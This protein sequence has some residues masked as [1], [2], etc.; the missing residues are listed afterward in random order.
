MAYRLSGFQSTDTI[1]P[2]RPNRIPSSSPSQEP[3]PTRPSP[4]RSSMP[5]IL[6][7]SDC[8]SVFT[9]VYRK[10]NLGRHRR[11]NHGIEKVSFPCEDDNCSK[12]FRRTD[13]R[14]KHYLK[15]HSH[16]ISGPCVPHTISQSHQSIDK[17]NQFIDET[18]QSVGE[19]SETSD[20]WDLVRNQFSR[21]LPGLADKNQ[22]SAAMA[23][24]DPR[25]LGMPNE[26]EKDVAY[27]GFQHDSIFAMP[28]LEQTFEQTSE[29]IFEP[30]FEPNLEWDSSS[31]DEH[32]T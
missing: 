15:H 7:C 13:A 8:S 12:K 2:A 1:R 27:I 24:Y 10:G 19:I 26:H 21:P 6:P 31:M 29:Q 22:Y 30:V 9:G 4:T 14:R 23:P 20:N 25:M 18:G 5:V 11:Q 17:A 28:A 32:D 3:R 16:L